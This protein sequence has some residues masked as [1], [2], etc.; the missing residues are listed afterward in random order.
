MRIPFRRPRGMAAL[1]APRHGS[2]GWTLRDY[3]AYLFPSFC[4]SALLIIGCFLLGAFF[5]GGPFPL[6][7]LIGPKGTA[8][9]TTARIIKALLDP[10]SDDERGIPRNE[11]DFAIHA[12]NCWIPCFGNISGMPRWLSD[13][14]CRLS[15]G[16]A[17]GTRKLYTNDEESVICLKRPAIITGISDVIEESDLKDRVLSVEL[18]E[19]DDSERRTE[20]E[21]WERFRNVQPCVLAALLDCVCVALANR[22]LI[23][24]AR[25]N[26]L[27][28]WHKNMLAAFPAMGFDEGL[29]DQMLEDNR[30][31]AAASVIEGSWV[32]LAVIKLMSTRAEHSA[33]PSD[34]LDHLRNVAVDRIYFD[35]RHWPGDARVLSAQLR[36]LEPDLRQRGIRI[37]FG[38]TGKAPP[39][40]PQA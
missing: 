14:F 39:Y 23:K 30:A 25:L 31:N 33:T 3:L 16:G 2:E 9:S 37:S 12:R 35:V 6:L 15:T 4:E 24:P 1:T 13:A 18:P 10:Y 32:A 5:P 40:H 36:R 34:L 21:I 29:L 27:A 11:Q 17:F 8:K 19:I 38:R 7:Q 20:E 22:D 28:D 26:R